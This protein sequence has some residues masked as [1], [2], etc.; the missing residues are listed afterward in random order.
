MLNF[1]GLTHEKQS[2]FD[3]PGGFLL[4]IILI[5]GSPPKKSFGEF[6][7]LFG[8]II[9]MTPIPVAPCLH[10]PPID[11]EQEICAFHPFEINPDP[12]AELTFIPQRLLPPHMMSFF[13]QQTVS[14]YPLFFN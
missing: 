13:F 2:Q 12:P 8:P 7:V 10:D 4:V 5:P 3:P 1:G 11:I 14:F 9:K 6:Q